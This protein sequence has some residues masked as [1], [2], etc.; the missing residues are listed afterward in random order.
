MIK[1]AA[2][3]NSWKWWPLF[4]LYPYGKRNTL[5]QELIVDQVWSLEQIQGIYYVSVPIRMT[6]V[7]VENGLMLFNPLPP[8]VEL[9]FYLEKLIKNFGPVLSIIL[10]TAS[11][12]EHKI[13]LPSLSRAFPSAELWICPGQWSF[14]LQLSNDFLGISSKRTKILV[15]EGYPHNEICEWFSL[16][17]LD[18]GLGRFQEISCFHRPS[19]TLLVTDALVGIEAKPPIIFDFDPTPLLFHAREIGT[20][21]LEDTIETREK[22]WYRLI[23]FASFLKPSRL[24]IPTFPEII[25]NSFHPK[26]R[27][28]KSH[29]GIYPFK[30][31]NDWIESAKKLIGKDKPL[32]QIFPVLKELVFPR[33]K[34]TFLAWLKKIKSL[35]NLKYL[36]PA[37]Y[38]APLDFN[39]QS[40]EQLISR[41]MS[42]E[43]DI[44]HEESSFLRS[45]DQK[46]L[47]L[48]IVPRKSN[49]EIID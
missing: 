16:G 20:D 10:P 29:F 18:L 5:F 37:H 3:N 40:C 34:D 27:N 2:L 4:P 25:K 14:P 43:K 48:K 23:L 7:R 9:K 31:R 19:Q 44:L 47:E 33:S 46:L 49:Y 11:G 13:S 36:V 35:R 38:S 42:D 24:D 26:L 8:T 12:L 45:L 32:I 17:P 1:D 41:L 30:W 21:P 6:V 28:F 15:K 22:G 39:K